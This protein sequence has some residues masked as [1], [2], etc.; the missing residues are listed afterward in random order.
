[1]KLYEYQ[2]KYLAQLPASC[3]MGADTGT[4]KTIMALAHYNRHCYSY[5]LLIIAPASKVRTEDWEREVESFGISLENVTVVSYERATRTKSIE[6]QVVG[7]E[8]RYWWQDYVAQNPFFVLI[9]DEVHKAKNP[10]SL[11]G[12]GIYSLATSPNC[13]Q[14]I[15]LS[16]TPLPNG[17]VDI[18]NYGKIFGW[19]KHKTEF[20]NR[21][22]ITY[23]IPN[24]HWSKITGYKEADVMRQQWDS[25]AK[26]LKKSDALDL[27]RLKY[28]GVK[29]PK[30]K[31]Y[32]SV[33]K[34]R[35]YRGEELDNAPKLVN[36]LRRTLI[37]DRVKWLDDFLDGTSGHTVIFYNYVE[38]REAVLQIIPKDV[39]V[40]RQ[41]GEKHEIPLKP[42][43]GNLPNKTV[44]L[45]HY[46]SGGTGVEM[47]YADKIIYLSP[48]YSY[49][50]FSQSIGRVYRNGQTVP[51]TAYLLYTQDTIDAAIWACIRQKRTFDQELW[52]KQEEMA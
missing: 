29:I 11:V 28:Q 7:K 47:T 23:Q 33:R 18:C 52:L 6:R 39:T 49:A 38:E 24:Q 15:G 20:F 17:W 10:Q 32:E 13:K 25:V 40:F 51:V 45:A 30:P 26:P 46:K 42:E 12:K 9:A 41:D 31:A 16:A 3:I 4:G 44:T 21:H 1:M 22:V 2:K 37:D 43:W 50:D 48:T 8:K 27:P 34:S 35:I 36:A 14:F 19:W 5:P